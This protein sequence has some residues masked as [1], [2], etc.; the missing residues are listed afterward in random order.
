MY[1]E[2]RLDALRMA[3]LAFLTTVEEEQKRGLHFFETIMS[4]TDDNNVIFGAFENERLVGSVGV[5]KGDRS[6]HKHRASIWGM[7]VD[8]RQRGKGVGSALLDL[9]MQHA[10]NVMNVGLIFL[11][12]EAQNTAAVKLYES[13]GFRTW[14]I[15]PNAVFEGGVFY[16]DRHMVWMSTTKGLPCA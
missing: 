8:E 6:K 5:I 10:Q 1:Y 13:K 12:V 4:R 11:S 2:S 16:D 3:P 7:F 14:G 15:E 9:A